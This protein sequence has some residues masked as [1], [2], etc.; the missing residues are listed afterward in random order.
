MPFDFNALIVLLNTIMVAFLAYFTK[1]KADLA[2]KLNTIAEVVTIPKEVPKTPGI[3]ELWN[4]MNDMRDTLN[5]T[6]VAVNKQLRGHGRTLQVAKGNESA[7]A[8]P[9]LIKNTGGV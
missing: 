8:G 1:R 7:S 5:K 3:E 2:E 9:G 4:E 6:L